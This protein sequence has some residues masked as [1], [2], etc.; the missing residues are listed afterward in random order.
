M[1][2]FRGALE[3]STAARHALPRVPCWGPACACPP[4]D[5]GGIEGYEDFLKAIGDPHHPEHEEFLDRIGGEF[6]V[7]VFDVDEV[8]KILREMT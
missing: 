4:E 2:G 5:V 3:F 8:D 6:D 1:S 7:K